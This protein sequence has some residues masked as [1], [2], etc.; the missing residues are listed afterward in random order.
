[1]AGRSSVVLGFRFDL[2]VDD[3]V[4]TVAKKSAFIQQVAA[5]LRLPNLR[6]L[7]DRV[8][9]IGDRYDVV[10]SR[11]F[12]TLTDFV[13][14]SGGAL[15]EGGVWVAMKGK[16]PADEV[17]ALPPEVEL[18]HVEHL[19]IPGLDAD[20]CLLWLRRRTA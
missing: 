8:E 16:Y 11:A 3:C 9:R 12:A 1:M 2:P 10:T 13:T 5:E 18:F 6:G 14:L 17:A 20:R 19:R 7:H 15:S 4:D